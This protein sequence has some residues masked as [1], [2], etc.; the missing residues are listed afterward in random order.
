[1]P[2][3]H[4]IDPFDLVV[5]SE[6]LE[7]LLTLF[8]RL[9]ERMTDA[10]PKAA[11]V[12]EDSKDPTAKQA[13]GTSRRHHYHKALESA[14]SDAGIDCVTRWTEPATWSFPVVRLGGFSATIGV[15]EAKYRGA[16]KS[17]RSKSKYVQ[18][19]CRRNAVID[20]QNDL[21]TR[22]DKPEALIPDGSLGG[23]VVAQY[24]W[25]TPTKP[26]FLG[27]WV[28][29]SDLSDVFYVRSFDEIIGMLRERLSLA[30][31][32]AKKTVE[33]K[34]LRRKKKPGSEG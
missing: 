29:S 21:F 3:R 7:R 15:V 1:M 12:L 22:D 18:D 13:R 27:F 34:P 33:R 8:M 25:T 14:A 11:R 6:D 24:D 32:P 17:L 16:G 26:A 31:R 5:R 4:Y 10:F 23:L 19:L 9:E 20:P 30:K 28:P 2:H